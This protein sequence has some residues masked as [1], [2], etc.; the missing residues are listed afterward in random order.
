MYS[1]KQRIAALIGIIFLV[2]L[3]VA[4]LICAIFDFDGSGKLF[5]ACLYASIAVPILLWIY[6]WLYGKMKE[7]NNSDDSS[8]S[9]TISKRKPRK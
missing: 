9:I 5:Q 2:L 1:K 4:T 7:Q 3:Y 6:I 8:D